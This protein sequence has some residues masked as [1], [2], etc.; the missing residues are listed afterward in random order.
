MRGPGLG[1]AGSDAAARPVR[2]RVCGRG[3][4]QSGFLGLILFPGGIKHYRSLPEPAFC[5]LL[6]VEWGDWTWSLSGS[7]GQG[8]IIGERSLSALLTGG[9]EK[10]VCERLLGSRSEDKV[11]GTPR[12][13]S[14]FSPLSLL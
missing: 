8:S 9:W 6:S 7:L 14:P 1:A 13:P 11:G 2:P 10:H 12:V 3:T 4:A 5:S